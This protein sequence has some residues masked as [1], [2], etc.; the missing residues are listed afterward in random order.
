MIVRIEGVLTALGEGSAVIEPGGGLTYEVLLSAYTAG[1]L[2]GKIGQRITLHS[3]HYF[4]SMNQGATLVPRLAGFETEQDKQ[5]FE[6]FTTCKGIG[7]RKAL[8]ALT[9][10][11]CQVAAAIADRDVSML[12]SLPE[13]GKRTAETVIATLHGKVDAFLGP[14]PSGLRATGRADGQIAAA[15]GTGRQALELLVQLG[16]NRA[17]AMQW[18]DRALRDEDQPRDTQQLIERVYEIKAG[19]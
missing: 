3:L 2:G 6:L 4:D 8:R 1:R 15:A 12:Q 13:I 7:H 11:T 17:Q 19:A 16:E 5:F 9:L 14:A 10:D 18:I